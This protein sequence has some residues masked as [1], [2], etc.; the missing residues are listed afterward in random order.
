LGE[1]AFFELAA[2]RGEAMSVEGAAGGGKMLAAR[3]NATETRALLAGLDEVWVANF[4]GPRQTVISGSSTGI[5]AAKAKFDAAGVAAQQLAV[6]AA[7]H[8]PFMDEPRRRFAA[9]LAECEFAPPR[10]PVFSNVSASAYAGAVDEMRGA[11]ADQLVREVRFVEQIEAMH[12]AGVRVFLEVGPA[13]VLTGLTREILKDRSHI[14]V[15][16]QPTR[17]AG[18]KDFLHTL[19]QLAVAGVD[20]NF[21]RL[22]EGRMLAPI[23]R[24]ELARAGV[25]EHPAHVWLLNGAYCRPAHEPRRVNKPAARLATSDAPDGRPVAATKVAIAPTSISAPVEPTTTPSARM[26]SHGNGV[27]HSPTNRIAVAAKP[28]A[29]PAAVA[30]VVAE[31]VRYQTAAQQRVDNF[32]SDSQSSSSA[33]PTISAMDL[34]AYSEFQ[35]TMRRFLE[36]QESVLSQLFGGAAE[37]VANARLASSTANGDSSPFVTSSIE[38]ASYNGASTTGSALYGEH[39]VGHQN[40]HVHPIADGHAESN[41]GTGATAPV[42]TNGS[43]AAAAPISTTP[44]ESRQVEKSAAQQPTP[45]AKAPAPLAEHAVDF[46]A[47]LLEIVADRTGYPTDML[48]LDTNLEGELGIDSIKRVEIIAAFRRQAIPQMSEPPAEFM[49]RLTTAKTMQA[50]LAIVAEMSGAG[51]G[52]APPTAGNAAEH[53][54]GKS[55]AID[56]SSPQAAVAPVEIDSDDLLSTLVGIV[57]DRTGYPVDMLALDTNLEGELGIDSIKRVEIIAAF[58]RHALPQMGEPPADFMERLTTAKTMRAILAAVEELLGRPAE[59]VAAQ[60]P[61]AIVAVPKSVAEPKS[62]AAPKPVAVPAPPKTEIP[63]LSTRCRRATLAVVDAPIG[64]LRPLS[65]GL[66]V[67]VADQ[68]GVAQ[69]LAERLA[70]DSRPVLLLNPQDLAS[71]EVA[72]A[73][74]DPA[75]ERHGRIAGV[76]HGLALDQAS[77]FPELAAADWQLNIDREIKSLL[78]L[79]Q[80]IGPDLSAPD[81]QPIPVLAATLGGGDFSNEQNSEATHPWRGGL[82]GLVKVAAKEWPAHC[83]RLVDFVAPPDVDT[84]LKELCAPGPV[85]IGYREGRRLALVAVADEAPDAAAGPGASGLTSAS[86]VLVT[87][88]AKGITAQLVQEMAAHAPATYVLVGRSPMP[89]GEES[90]ET[91]AIDSDNGLRQAIIR[92]RRAAGISC[93]PADVEKA[94]AAIKSDREIR[95]TFAAIAAT[96]ARAFYR[97]CDLR[98][99][100]DVARM[101]DAVRGEFGAIHGL[102]HGA[103]VIEDRSIKDKTAESF[104]RVFT[105]KVAPLVTLLGSLELSDLRLVALFASTSG[106]FGNAG[107]CDYAA[108]NETLNRIARRLTTLVGCKVLSFN[109]GPWS[110]A[111]MVTPEV[112]GKMKS[113]GIA[114]IDVQGGREAAWR[115]IAAPT[116]G[117]P[118]IIYGDGPW[119][120]DAESKSHPSSSKGLTT[121][122]ET[123]EKFA[124]SPLLLGCPYRIDADGSLLARVTLD[125]AHPYLKDHS[126]DGK[127]VMPF[128]MGLGLM[129]ECAALAEPGW[130]VTGIEDMRLFSGVSLADGKRELCLRVEPIERRA[131][132]SLWRARIL[133]SPSAT[134]SLYE[135]RIRMATTALAPERASLSRI[136]TPLRMSAS[137]VYQRWL[138]HGPAYQAIEALVGIDENGVDGF[139]TVKPI[140]AVDDAT[141]RWVVDPVTLDI[142]PQMAL[143]WSRYVCD[144]AMLPNRLASCRLYG[145]IAPGPTEVL[146]RIQSGSDREL[147]VADAYIVRDGLVI[148]VLEGLEGAGSAHLNHVI[149]SASV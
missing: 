41:N 105:T 35:L 74:I 86:V 93:S 125:P 82:A 98:D 146:L 83:F 53:Q 3:A 70:E 49:E 6:A 148:C 30:Q 7:F 71:A 17:E 96:G 9:K 38:H 134:R 81:A 63:A 22:Y 141:A 12:D 34:N 25:E 103:G 47:C 84:V 109:W 132:E 94:L 16:T 77:S 127:A 29:S 2:A 66:W 100:A 73:K 124:A 126:I 143:V 27:A 20:V 118:R 48:A 136:A 144:V 78:F 61:P 39:E 120:A 62:V 28:Q 40:G 91:A 13:G 101:V 115:D 19:A 5:A 121:A 80:A 1:Q 11:L 68:Q 8:S 75:R 106:V 138:F 44:I 139:A 43:H 90:P 51:S 45:V 137:E 26:V 46:A 102:V 110:G 107:Q 42:T 88:G 64:E 142:C 111:G 15:A 147:Y 67:L 145:P 65:N 52:A 89:L 87:G 36:T 92:Q 72:Q 21:D 130:Q 33:G 59:S 129:A 32:P 85:E 18:T 24:A 56:H 133:A 31:P 55:P 112:A 4:N 69:S 54:N 122:N 97:P 128:T 113:Q 58:R 10:F 149:A 50:I 140:I 95:R 60:P 79:L 23:D 131:R 14:A 37:S 76:F 135:A 104:D 123:H 99:S 57:A 114:L 119:L 116:F 108:A 117:S